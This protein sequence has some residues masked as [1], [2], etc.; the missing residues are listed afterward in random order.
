MTTETFVIQFFFVCFF[1][2]FCANEETRFIVF[3]IHYAKGIQLKVGGEIQSSK[4]NLAK[5][6]KVL[7]ICFMTMKIHLN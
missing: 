7:P 5:V 2:F 3:S 1:G 4:F 6:S